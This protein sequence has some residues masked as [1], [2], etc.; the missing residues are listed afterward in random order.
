MTPYC[1]LKVYYYCVCLY[2]QEH[3]LETLFF[4]VDIFRIRIVLKM[5]LKL[6]KRVE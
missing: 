4:F 2:I 1:G 5:T 3:L 6:E